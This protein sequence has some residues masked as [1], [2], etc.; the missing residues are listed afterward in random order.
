MLGLLGANG[1]DVLINGVGRAHVPVFADPL[2]RRQD[3]D[4]LAQLIGHDVPAFADVPVQRQS[5]V[6][7]ENVNAPQIGIDAVGQSNVDNA[8]DAAEGHRGFG[9]VASERIQT[10]ARTAG[11]QNSKMCLSSFV[12]Y[13]VVSCREPTTPDSL[14]RA[15]SRLRHTFARGAGVSSHFGLRILSQQAR[16]AAF[17]GPGRLRQVCRDVRC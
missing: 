10:F 1:V 16:R 11:Q 4:E 3:L 6:L 17:S 14:P 8:V 2:H 13:P 9:A 12:P 7:S 5:L 15:P